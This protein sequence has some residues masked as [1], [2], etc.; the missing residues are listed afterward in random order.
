VLSQTS[1]IGV[2][3]AVA[4]P[5]QDLEK[6]L[7]PFLDEPQKD[8][9][10]MLTALAQDL[11]EDAEAGA[12]SSG[13]NR[14]APAAT[15]APAGQT[16]PSE[17]SVASSSDVPSVPA[18]SSQPPDLPYG[19]GVWSDIYA[20]DVDI[21]QQG[22]P[23]DQVALG[24]NVPNWVGLDDPTGVID[25]ARIPSWDG[26]TPLGVP[27][28][29]VPFYTA[30]GGLGWLASNGTVWDTAGYIR[31]NTFGSAVADANAMSVADAMTAVQ[32][33]V[34]Q[35]GRPF[36]LG[37]GRGLSSDSSG[38]AQDR[39]PLYFESR[40]ARQAQAV[41]A[42]RNSPYG[43]SQGKSG[44]AP[45][46]RLGMTRPPMRPGRPGMGMCRL[47]C[48][49]DRSPFIGRAGY[50]PFLVRMA[51]YITP[52]FIFRIPFWLEVSLHACEC[53]K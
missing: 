19:N 52:K 43:F 29:A 27:A 36:T 18:P 33:N 53:H 20:Y 16:P 6:A 40:G 11:L 3:P 41:L 8:F 25:P 7:P 23:A 31:D 10:Y 24:T 30:S 37:E 38:A 35:A 2:N 34:S 5:S 51:K 21:P 26:N 42:L 50:L 45:A 49:P 4:I 39:Y 15:I 46:C 14:T 12:N 47:G 44:L 9:A 32:S 28:N 13:T 22:I 48:L 17:P 1:P